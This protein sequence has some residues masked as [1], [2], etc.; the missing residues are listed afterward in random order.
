M[1]GK[2]AINWQFAATGQPV[3]GILRDGKFRAFHSLRDPSRE[4]SRVDLMYENAGFLLILGG[5]GLYHIPVTRP[6]R[7]ILLAVVDRDLFMECQV[8]KL[9]SGIR[10]RND[11]VLVLRNS[12]ETLHEYS[13]RLETELRRTYLP[14]FH[15]NYS[16]HLHTALEQLYGKDAKTLL[17]AMSR[18]LE[19]VSSDFLDQARHGRIWF[20]NIV[21][22]MRH[23]A[24]ND[25]STKKAAEILENFSGKEVIVCGAGPSLEEGVE[26][27]RRSNASV[28]LAAD[29]AVPI[30]CSYGIRT[31]ISVTIDPQFYSLLHYLG[32]E[33]F[34]KL[35]LLDGGTHPS[36]ARLAEKRGA[37]H[38]P[39]A[40]PHPMLVYLHRRGIPFLSF[41]RHSTNAGVA[42]FSASTLL[43]PAS[44]KIFGLDF[45]NSRG[46]P[47]AQ[48]SFHHSWTHGRSLRINPPETYFYRLAS[49]NGSARLSGTPQQD[50]WAYGTANMETF[51]N[52]FEVL[53][54]D[55]S[56]L[57][58]KA[59]GIFEIPVGQN[60]HAN[61]K[62]PHYNASSK[63]PLRDIV[64]EIVS[65]L[66]TALQNINRQA[67]APE[68]FTPAL[69]ALSPLI[70]WK[71][72]SKR[73][74]EVADIIEVIQYARERISH[75]IEL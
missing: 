4:S 18:V 24:N 38:I 47:Y 1:T 46:I 63:I 29:T 34:P 3:P 75:I 9:A 7:R 43:R 20:S 45:A 22:N 51:K 35:L 36:I 65:E 56:G 19:S 62:L 27:I 2:T 40:S 72:A 25:E 54:G 68:I 41:P 11:L 44:I 67:P 8:R 23:L 14:L 66:D 55:F 60:P 70:A 31:D 48:G 58:R 12:D 50:Y 17:E 74:L 26:T 30:L 64:G 39:I 10:I 33:K 5:A 15:K 57:G 21:R 69:Q 71:T 37:Y 16:I 61:K 59:P 32:L 53:I 13:Q 42:A 52:E 73:S 28:I 49:A 6:G